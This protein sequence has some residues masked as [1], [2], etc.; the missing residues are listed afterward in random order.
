MI[1][2]FLPSPICTN[3]TCKVGFNATSNNYIELVEREGEII[4]AIFVVW[5]GGELGENKIRSIALL[6][7]FLINLY[8]EDFSNKFMSELMGEL[9]ECG[10]SSVAI[11]TERFLVSATTVNENKVV[12][13]RVSS[14]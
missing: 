2:Q 4:E 10:A 3:A 9:G 6:T 7:R 14:N 12:R 8:G 5:L 1:F 11:S 13:V